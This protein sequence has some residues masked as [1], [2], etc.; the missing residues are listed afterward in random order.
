M[1]K[2][3]KPYL[4]I[5]RNIVIEYVVIPKGCSLQ[6]HLLATCRC[7]ILFY[8]SGFQLQH[9]A[10]GVDVEVQHLASHGPQAYAQHSW[11]NTGKARHYGLHTDASHRFERGVDYKLARDAMERATRLL[12][13]IVGGEPGEI[14][15]VASDED[16][17]GDRHVDL[18]ARRLNDVL[19][20]EIDRTN[21]TNLSK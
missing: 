4:A 21:T 11:E 20:M 8:D 1:Y 19:G 18:R 7:A 5:S 13:D 12:M 10:P 14:V 17:P 15:E 6:E 2:S 9:R 3:V 16:I